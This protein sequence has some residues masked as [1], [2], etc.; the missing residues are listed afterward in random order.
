[1]HCHDGTART[2]PSQ[3]RYPV[4]LCE[5]TVGGSGIR[6]QEPL[7]AVLGKEDRQVTIQPTSRTTNIGGHRRWFGST[8]KHEL[9]GYECGYAPLSVFG[10]GLPN[11]WLSYVNVIPPLRALNIEFV[12]HS[13]CFLPQAKRVMPSWPQASS[14]VP[15]GRNHFSFPLEDSDGLT[16]FSRHSPAPQVSHEKKRGA[17]ASV[18]AGKSRLR[19]ITEPQKVHIISATSPT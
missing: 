11:Q 16:W 18:D 13:I 17:C 4:K 15:R 1:M 8:L 19:R 9:C 6:K 14:M 3:V 12:G 7:P 2:Q 5:I 10:C